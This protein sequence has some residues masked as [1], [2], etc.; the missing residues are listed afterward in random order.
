MIHHMEDQLG[1]DLFERR[2]GQIFPT[3]QADLLFRETIGLFDRV[4]RVSD[5][6]HSL[7][8][9]TGERLS[10]VSYHSLA[11]QTV[12]K[13][14]RAVATHYPGLTFS[15]DAKGPDDQIIDII[16][17]DADIGIAGNVPDLASLKRHQLGQD[18]IVAVLPA[19]H[20]TAASPCLTFADAAAMPCITSP[21]GSPVGRMLSREF[22]IRGLE[23]RVLVSISSPTPVF[24]LVRRFGGVAL[25][26][27]MAVKT[28]GAMQGLIVKPLEASIRYPITAF[29][30]AEAPASRA[31]TLFL[32][33]LSKEFT[34]L[35][36]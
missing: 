29:W 5:L 32:E 10:V 4:R 26:G 31:R 35:N 23:L 7:R 12:P 3:L 22:E 11:V 28:I 34:S 36:P 16:R 17:A 1:Y 14:L 33:L 30:S 24:E 8:T 18:E 15:F 13:I 9:G 19:D 27:S 25:I 20:P 2:I 21:P 6:A